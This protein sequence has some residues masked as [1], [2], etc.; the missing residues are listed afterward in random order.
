MRKLLVLTLI[1]IVI[2]ASVGLGLTYVQSASAGNSDPVCPAPQFLR[3][4]DKETGAPVCGY[5]TGCPYGDSIPLG[6]ECDKFAP[7]TNLPDPDRDYYDGQGNRFD[8]M[9]NLVEAA[10]VTTQPTAVQKCGAQ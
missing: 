4:M 3:G 10:P 7:N 2:G 1:S 6:P 5:V 8:Y 9:G